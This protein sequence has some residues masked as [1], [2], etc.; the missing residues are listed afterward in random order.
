MIRIGTVLTTNS[1]PPLRPDRIDP[2]EPP[3][4]EPVPVEPQP[5]VPP[6]TWPPDPDVDEPDRSPEEYPSPEEDLALA[7]MG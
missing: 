1:I 5:E 2:D 3:G 7:R 4:I 6:E